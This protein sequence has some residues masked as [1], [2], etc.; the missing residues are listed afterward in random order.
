MMWCVLVYEAADGP[1]DSGQDDDLLAGFFSELSEANKAKEQ[2]A[3]AAA[4]EHMQSLLTEKYI[5]Q[6]LG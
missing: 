2:Q 1:P 3:E 6:D 4:N 5:N